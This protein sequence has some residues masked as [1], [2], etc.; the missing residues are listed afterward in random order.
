MPVQDFAN[1]VYSKL[2]QKKIDRIAPHLGPDESILILDSCETSVPLLTWLPFIGDL[3]RRKAFYV[4][5]NQR[6][7]AFFLKRN[8][9]SKRFKRIVSMPFSHIRMVVP[10][11]GLLTSK[12][13]VQLVN[14]S[15]HV[16]KEL[17]KSTAEQTKLLTLEGHRTQAELST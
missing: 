6:I 8:A 12:V 4:V 10:T 11:R 9:F 14:G 2:N 13:T 1:E 3:F 17:R 16:L 15:S 7:A 5:T